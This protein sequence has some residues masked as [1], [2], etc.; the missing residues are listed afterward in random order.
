MDLRISVKVRHSVCEGSVRVRTVWSAWGPMDALC[1]MRICEHASAGSRQTLCARA[2]CWGGGG[3]RRTCELRAWL[4]HLKGVP[5]QSEPGCTALGS[6]LSLPQSLLFAW[7]I[8][9]P[10]IYMTCFDGVPTDARLC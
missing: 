8:I 1:A 10:F 7:R 3:K 4:G 5:L 2:G 9:F 6:P